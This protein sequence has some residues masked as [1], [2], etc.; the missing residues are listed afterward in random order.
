LPKITDINAG[1]P[2]L[3]CETQALIQA[4]HEANETPETEDVIKLYPECR[5]VLTSSTDRVIVG[6]Y[7]ITYGLPRIESPIVILGNG[8]TI[9]RIASEPFNFIVV[10]GTGNLTLNELTLKN[11][12]SVYGGAILNR[13]QLTITGS[14]FYT[15]Y[16]DIAGGAI[17]SDSLNA[18]VSLDITSSEFSGNISGYVEDSY[19]GYGGAI[20]SGRLLLDPYSV[21][22]IRIS[23]CSFLN[24]TSHRFGGAL[25]LNLAN[26][27]IEQSTFTMNKAI[28]GGAIVAFTPVAVDRSV[29]YQNAAN[30]GGAIYSGE[31]DMLSIVNSTFSQNGTYRVVSGGFG[32]SAVYV[33]DSSVIIN[34]STFAF[35]GPPSG[36]T[37]LFFLGEGE[38]NIGN[39]VFSNNGNDCLLLGEGTQINQIGRNFDEDPICP[40]DT[41]DDIRV[42]VLGFYG[43]ST[44]T[45]PLL[46]GSPAIDTAEDICPDSDQRGE[47][48]PNGS[49]C[50]SGAFE[51]TKVEMVDLVNFDMLI[52]MDDVPVVQERPQGTI[53]RPALCQEGPDPAYPTISALTEQT[54]V[55]FIGRDGASGYVLIEH[56]EYAIPCWVDVDF[57]EMTAIDITD[58]VVIDAPPL[59]EDLPGSGMVNCGPLSM[60]ACNANSDC[61]WI[62]DLTQAGVGRC[63]AK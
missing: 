26:V 10:H 17:Y 20:A 47:A 32:G 55:E 60:E 59:T 21:Q 43:G 18:D 23:G 52:P 38:W 2:T 42:G 16:A 48:R 56:P 45:I 28:W 22:L 40:F 14:N 62:P 41:V 11:G 58:L 37:S 24:N 34:Y 13:G 53:L 5:Y 57:V 33:R 50:D 36:T 3:P 25:G 1:Q 49:A 61:I 8:A 29:F 30:K 6:G 7:T 31:G 19:F 4:I 54:R 39:S 63:E 44:L 12:R 46:D 15:N 27:V 35:N 9:E 51:R